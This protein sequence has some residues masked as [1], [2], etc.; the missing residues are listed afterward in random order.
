MTKVR[1]LKEYKVS[2]NGIN[3]V[4]YNTGDIE[5]VS[6][7][8]LKNMIADGACEIIE[9]KAIE[10]DYIENKAIESSPRRRGRKPKK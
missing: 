1:L 5:N 2:P 6:D 9:E 10:K 8:I 4:K 3:I 7:E